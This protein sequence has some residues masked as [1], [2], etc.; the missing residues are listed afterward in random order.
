MGV[1]PVATRA[2]S[3]LRSA[4]TRP[5]QAAWPGLPGLD[6]CLG[7]ARVVTYD[8]EAFGYLKSKL[9]PLPF[10]IGL[11]PYLKQRSALRPSTTHRRLVSELHA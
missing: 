4:L 9:F 10:N 8:D 7:S 2:E 3:R 1:S 6:A 11:G 5:R